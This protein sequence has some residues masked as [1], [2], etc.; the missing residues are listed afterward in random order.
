MIMHTIVWFNGPSSDELLVTLPPQD[1]EIGC[2]YIQH[3]RPV[4]MV[5]AYDLL[6]VDRIKQDPTIEYYTRPDAAK[7]KWNVLK[8]PVLNSTNS[9]IMAV[10]VAMQKSM[11]PIFI[12]GCDWGLTDKST[13]DPMYNKGPQRK[14][15]NDMRHK[16]KAITQ[17]RQCYV[18]NDRPVDV[19][20]PIIGR[21][22]FMVKLY[23]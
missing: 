20:L 16:L 18:V 1:L 21:N 15:T 5:T 10:Y 11:N 9:G 17:G 7:H 23:K 8:D 12:V 6:V 4:H 13:Q 3:V 19:P 14:Y 22:D 2:N